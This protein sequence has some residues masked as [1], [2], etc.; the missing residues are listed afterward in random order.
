MPFTVTVTTETYPPG[1]EAGLNLAA[2][3]FAARPGRT[4]FAS[5]RSSDEATMLTDAAQLIGALQAQG[6]V[7]ERYSLDAV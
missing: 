3:R 5:S 1:R 2:L 4:G 7:V 6:I